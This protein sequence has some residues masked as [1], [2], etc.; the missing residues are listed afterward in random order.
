[1]PR[2]F[3]TSGWTEASARV[4]Q[5]IFEVII[6]PIQD[7]V[8][9]SIEDVWDII[10]DKAGYDPEKAQVRLNWGSEKTPEINM[11]DMLKA[12]ELGLI[13]SE[14]FRKNAVKFGWQLWEPKQSNATQENQG[15]AIA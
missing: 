9:R 12:A 14:E 4:G 3:T 2:L 13:R 5:D 11:V 8:K 15:G 1:M 10:I 6:N 7:L